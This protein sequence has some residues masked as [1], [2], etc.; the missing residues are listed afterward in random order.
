L[1]SRRTTIARSCSW[2]LCRVSLPTTVR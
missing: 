1:R 2:S